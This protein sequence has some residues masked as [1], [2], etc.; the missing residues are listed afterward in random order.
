VEEFL[1]LRDERR[2]AGIGVV[3]VGRGP[4]RFIGAGGRR[5]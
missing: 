4:Q 2:T 5:R 1:E 3:E